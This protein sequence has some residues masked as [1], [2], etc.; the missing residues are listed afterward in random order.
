MSFGNTYPV[1]AR[2]RR[3][4]EVRLEKGGGWI[5]WALF[6]GCETTAA[7]DKNSSSSTR[8]PGSAD[9]PTTRTPQPLPRPP[10]RR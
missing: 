4:E 8:S 3:G 1:K 9:R 7:S 5:G 6:R 10:G 2:E